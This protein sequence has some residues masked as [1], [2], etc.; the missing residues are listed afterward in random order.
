M[1]QSIR[2]S[3]TGWVVWFIVGLI[4]IPF[5]FVGIESFRTGS[6]DPVV[7]EVGDV[8][9]TQGQFRA[10]YEQRY[11]QLR[12]M[13]GDN[14]RADLFDT[15]QFRASV[16]DDMAQEALL[17]Q[18]ADERGLRA[19]D[20]A[21]FNYISM[22]PSFQV[23]GRFSADVYR[24]VLARQGYTPDGFEAQLRNAL[25]IEQLRQGVLASGF[26]TEGRVR[27]LYALAEQ[28]RSLAYVEVPAARYR[29]E[30]DAQIADADIAARY[31]E[32]QADYRAPERLKLAYVV[33]DRDALPAGQVPEDDVLK[34]L[35]DAEKARFVTPGERKAR[36]ILVNF[37]DDK[38][39][40]RARAE[41][42]KAQLDEGAEFAALAQAESDDVGSRDAGG[43][44]GWISRGQMVE[45]FEKALFALDTN[46]VS[47]PV[48]TEFG[49][50]LIRADEV[51]SELTRTLDDPEVRASLIELFQNRERDR[52]FQAQQ[53]QLEQIA[54]E[55]PGSLAPVAEA[56]GVT[57]QE[58]DWFTR[59]GGDGLSAEPQV[60]AAAFSPEV[61]QDDENSTPLSLPDGRIAVIRK[62][63]Y[64]AP[65]QKPLTE[66]TAEVREALVAERARAKARE[67][68]QAMI[69]AARSREVSLA[70]IAA[71]RGLSVR[72]TG[73]VSRAQEDVPAPVLSTL[74]QLPRPADGQVSL[75][76]ASLRDGDQAVV[77]LSA[78]DAPEPNPV[79]LDEQRQQLAELTAGQEFSALQRALRDI[80]PVETR[81]PEADSG[82]AADPFN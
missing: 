82:E 1:L 20:A 17:R 55:N 50:H 75:G 41:S 70:D 44:L 15:A 25:A 2:D 76:L 32:T 13:L 34:V 43:D 35:Y 18:Y 31:D 30:V 54:F 16:L 37:G 71:E 78:V 80:I 81:L 27:S 40:A 5:V 38:D 57:V 36:H 12:N 46:E 65:R 79:V 6:R 45:D 58:T 26:V 22:V 69:E 61:L 68:A 59:A 23:D 52:L 72:A 21:V 51:K 47:D 73:P 53:E 11:Q 8:E 48:E 29:A 74:F 60:L 14:F 10:A 19:T 3:L 4:S 33:L 28:R 56:L 9:I 66:V 63:A 39:R 7:A 49:F 77:A 62:A 64:E 24:E 67:E 42:L